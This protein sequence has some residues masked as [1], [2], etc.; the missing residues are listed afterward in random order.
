MAVLRL[1]LN[2]P[3][4]ARHSLA[5]LIRDF[6]ANEGKDRDTTGFKAI[7]HAMNVLLSYFQFERD[8]KIEESIENLETELE[9][10]K[11][12]QTNR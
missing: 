10:M 3:K 7:V 9:A 12:A 5:R 1:W 11:N 6:Q 4:N 8:M 2:T